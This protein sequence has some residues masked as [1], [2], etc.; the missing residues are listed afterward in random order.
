M[1]VPMH[2]TSR[3]IHVPILRSS[4]QLDAFLLHV[5]KRSYTRV[6][7]TTKFKHMYVHE[8]EYTAYVYELKCTGNNGADT[9]RAPTLHVIRIEGMKLFHSC[10]HT[11][12]DAAY[13]HS[14]PDHKM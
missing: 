1:H 4:C 3:L 9:R 2:V 5:Q 11:A 8:Q 13:A 7:E 6:L 12:T 14:F 10:Q